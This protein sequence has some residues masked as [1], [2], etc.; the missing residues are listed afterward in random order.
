MTGRPV[1]SDELA[2]TICQRIANGEGLR[3]I[4]RDDDMPGRQTVLDWL[5]DEKYAAFRAK[6]ARARE[7]Q[8]DFLDEAMA[9][10]AD[11]AT[12]ENV[13]VAR[14][15]VDTMK[16]RASKLAPKKYG[17]K[18]DATIGNPDG[19]PIQERSPREIAMAVLS[20]IRAAQ[21]DGGE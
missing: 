21:T 5:N 16:W 7:A 15:R 13:Q 4:C 14:L 17:D 9:D 3:A 8:A 19:T 20:V 1:Y 18:L 11:N 12:P 2:E 10:V 6:Y